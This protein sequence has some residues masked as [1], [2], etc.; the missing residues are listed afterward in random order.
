MPSLLGTYVSANYG[1]MT[2]QDTYGGVTFSNFGTRN[3]AFLKIVAGNTSIDFTAA[4][5][6][7]ADITTT[8]DG[9]SLNLEVNSNLWQDAL[10]PFAVAVRSIQQVAELYFVGSPATSGANSAFV[11]AVAID[12][13]SDANVSSNTEIATYPQLTGSNSFVQLETYLAGA[14]G[15]SLSNITVTQLT[16]AGSSIASSTTYS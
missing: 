16:A 6:T 13:A 8:T 3:L 4:P 5:S 14:L 9:V 12:T 1:R 2:S 15:T 7:D 10:S 11:V